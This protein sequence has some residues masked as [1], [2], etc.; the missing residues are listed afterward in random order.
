MA[1]LAPME[2]L[3]GE[4]FLVGGGN[5]GLLKSLET[6]TK[7]FPLCAMRPH[8]SSLSSG[9]REQ[10]LHLAAYGAQWQG[11]GSLQSTRHL[12]LNVPTADPRDLPCLM[13]GNERI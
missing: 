4:F 10:S 2:K 8:V 11:G 12:L 5:F 6:S 3:G 1:Q 7:T 13:I 9:D